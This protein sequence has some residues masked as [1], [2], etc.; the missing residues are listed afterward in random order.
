[1]TN[2]VLAIIV[3]YNDFYSLKSTAMA[4]IDQVEEVL[5]VDNGSSKSVVSAIECFCAS[6]KITL[7]LIGKNLGIGVALNLGV[8]YAKNH[9]YK[10]LLTMDQDSR[11]A[12]DMVHQLLQCAQRNPTAGLISANTNS[13]LI[14]TPEVFLSYAITSGNLV[15]TEKLLRL[16]GY[17]E[18]LFID[19]VDFDICLRIK[20][21]GY[22]I[23]QCNDA[24]MSHRL[25]NPIVFKI[26]KFELKYIQHS[27]LRRY[28]IF[29][30]NFYITRKYFS[31]NPIFVAKKNL[32]IVFYL[33]QILIFDELRMGNL[34]MISTGV[35]DFFRGKAG[36]YEFDK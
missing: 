27:P 28:Y 2:G 1:M 29:R 18:G 19:G 20:N 32:F 23:V 30:N 13:D 15:E 24:M 26:F 34:K 4:L 6:Q 10:W 14:G 17:D 35:L 3:S 21:A 16:N 8:T 33:F 12:T 5:V 7:N 36:A 11:A 31:T 25:G 9:G 22:D